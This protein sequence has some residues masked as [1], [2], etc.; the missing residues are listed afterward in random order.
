VPLPLRRRLPAPQCLF[1]QQRARGFATGPPKDP[2]D[3]KDDDAVKKDGQAGKPEVEGNKEKAKENE[4][5]PQLAKLTPEEEKMLDQLVSFVSM[6]VPKTQKQAIKE[7]M[8]EIKK[9]GIPPE[10]REKWTNW[11]VARSWT[12]PRPPRSHG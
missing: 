12:W 7:A 5:A 9:T 3:K 2:K 8:D 4:D 6:G 10:L 11:R 1:A